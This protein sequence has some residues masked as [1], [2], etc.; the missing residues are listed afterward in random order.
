VA[1]KRPRAEK[2]D[3][4]GA[5]HRRARIDRDSFPLRDPEV[6]R[7]A[8]SALSGRLLDRGRRAAAHPGHDG[9]LRRK[10]DGG[11]AIL[12][13]SVKTLY[14]KLCLYDE[15]KKGKEARKPG[16]DKLKTGGTAATRA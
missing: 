12:G 3:R 4:A 11:R 7:S 15:A 6:R 16:R 8:A 2:R 9:A 10:Q 14:N 5:H 13:I 1:G